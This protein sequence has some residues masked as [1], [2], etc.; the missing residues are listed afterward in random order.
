M[1]ITHVTIDLRVPR[2]VK[3]ASGSIWNQWARP[4][5]IMIVRDKAGL[6]QPIPIAPKLP[7]ESFAGGTAPNTF[8]LFT[9][10]TKRQCSTCM[11]A[12][13]P[14]LGGGGYCPARVPSN[15][16]G[17]PCCWC[18]PLKVTSP[19][20]Q[21]NPCQSAFCL[22]PAAF[23]TLTLANYLGVVFVPVVCSGRLPFSGCPGPGYCG[24]GR[25]VYR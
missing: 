2:I 17:S 22:V 16:S 9:W 20:S 7:A 5:A 13:R 1:R 14:E 23:P 11:S 15:Q 12:Y 19:L 25:A 8:L 3:F 24:R 18:S 21:L 10:R 6:R 4:D